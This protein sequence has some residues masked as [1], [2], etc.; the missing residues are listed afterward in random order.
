MHQRTLATLLVVGIPTVA[1]A[2]AFLLNEFDAKAT[3][4]G[5][6]TTASAQDASSIYYNVGGLG[7]VTGTQVRISGSV[8]IPEAS[9]TDALSG[10]KTDSTTDP[11]PLLGAFAGARLTDVFSVGIG[12]T[13]PFGLSVKW[14]RDAPV[15]EDNQE[16]TLRT[17]FITPAVGVDLGRWVPGLTIGGGLDV[18]PATIELRQQVFFGTDRGSAHLGGDAIGIGGRIGAMYTPPA[19]PWLSIGAM[20]RSQVTE[21]FDGT[22]D[23]D[24][25]SPYRPLL[26]PDGD[27]ETSLDLP[28][29]VA[30][31]I[32]IRPIERLELE[33]DA[34]WTDWSTFQTL[35]IDVPASMTTGTME[36][37]RP[38][39]YE[40]KVT[41]RAGVEY[42]FATHGAAVRA[43]YIYDPTPIP[44][45][46]LTA[47]LPDIDRHD[48]TAGGSV[49]I[50]DYDVHLS[51]L[52]VIED[53]R[54]TS[55]TPYMP[56][57][58]GTFEVSAWVGTLTLTGQFD[59]L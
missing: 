29:Q 15:A 34:I 49:A 48:V 12:F 52:Y 51:L 26:P 31:G 19:A 35:V 6:A 37:V 50:G 47:L 30:G 24:A 28:Q 5:N 7:A 41:I 32:A 4:R 55:T 36:I 59:R 25:P 33:A 10:M 54:S 20:W 40:D 23:F 13:T 46:T 42:Q 27:V 38:Q 45:T 57:H 53:D 16:V 43:G 58:K 18:V 44:S 9:F 22:A 17:F 14:P 56:A 8:V 2:N 1:S 21:D 39:N 3:G 11:Q